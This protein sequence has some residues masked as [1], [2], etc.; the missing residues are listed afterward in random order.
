M[1]PRTGL[2]LCSS[3]VVAKIEQAHFISSASTNR[4]VPKDTRF[5]RQE[6]KAMSD[7][8]NHLM[9]GRGG[10]EPPLTNVNQILSLA[11]LPIPPPAHHQMI[12]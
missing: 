11:R 2:S 4:Y 12:C 7:V 6:P 5:W 3:V 10:L 1:V 8:T 9:V